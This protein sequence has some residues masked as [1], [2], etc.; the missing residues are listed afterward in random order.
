MKKGTKIAGVL[1]LSLGLLTG[2]R[3]G[4][5]YA[6]DYVQNNQIFTEEKVEA[7]LAYYGGDTRYV[8]QRFNM[9][10]F[11]DPIYS[12]FNPQK[13]NNEIVVGFKDNISDE[14][15]EEMEDVL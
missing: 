7:D 12:H 6:E 9:F 15:M 2:H 1:L 11:D 3:V 4:N 13:I 10:L 5:N 8:D 14:F